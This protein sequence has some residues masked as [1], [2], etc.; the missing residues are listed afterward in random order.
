MKANY[1][2]ELARLKGEMHNPRIPETSLKH[3]EKR[4]DYLSEL[5]DA[6]F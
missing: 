1:E 4:V 5:S 2:S 6:I 3:L